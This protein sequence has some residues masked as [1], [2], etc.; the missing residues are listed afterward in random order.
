MDTRYFLSLLW[1]WGWLVILATALS[2]GLS[3]RANSKAPVLYQATTTLLVGRSLQS[4]NPNSNDLYT[5]QSLAKDYTVYATGQQVLQAT[6]NALK[7]NES[8]EALSQQ[9]DASSMQNSDTLD[10]K[11][12]N[13]DPKQAKIIADEV[14]RQLILFSPT[15]KAGDPQRQFAN[16]QMG[17]LQ[18]Q[19]QDAQAQIQDLQK[20]H[21]SATSAVTLQDLNN[22]IGVLQQKVRDWQNTY[23]QLSTFYKGSNI[24]YLSVV[25]PATVPSTPLGTS[26][27]YNVALAAVAGFLLA[28]G[29]IVVVEFVDDTVKGQVDAARTFG[30]PILGGI[31]WVRAAKKPSDRLFTITAPPSSTAEACR[32]L[33]ANVCF[34]DS[35]HATSSQL[36]LVTSPG[37]RD[38]KS[39][40]AANL[41]AAIAENGRSVILL[42]ANL[43]R[44]S[45][46]Q[47]FNLTNRE[48]LST[49]LGNENL[50]MESLVQST[51]VPS[52]RVLTS[53]PILPNPS[54]A[55]TSRVMTER[56]NQLRAL[57]EVVVVDAAAIL[58]AADVSVLATHCD[59]AVVVVR[60]EH[61]R[62]ATTRQA[63]DLLHRMGVRTP[64]VV[65]NGRNVGRPSF[66]KY[67]AVATADTAPAAQE[68]CPQLGMQNDRTSI[69][70]APSA[71][72]R[73]FA[74]GRP[75]K[76]TESHQQSYCLASGYGTCP[77]FTQAAPIARPGEAG[78]PSSSPRRLQTGH[79]GDSP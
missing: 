49:A 61:T 43:H 15:P 42:D 18:K 39:T 10:I 12:V 62:R 36:V 16:Q 56:L 59:A 54:G 66:Q 52:L 58:G 64:G 22:Q 63:I 47:Y 68:Q 37:P 20:Q 5:A 6:I 50:A 35:D 72:H 73:C 11:V 21:D 27:K 1:K 4:E 67:Y 32:F 14:A 19:I 25:S 65:L 44:P 70:L 30:L 76:V 8:W 38:G 9:I 57:A 55:L 33:G 48:G 7:L 40:V 45:A 53:G 31:R 13:T 17:Q 34:A 75:A 23:A 41:A 74:S 46:H 2:A 24:N 71:Q 69:V 3:Y 28:L 26:T 79:A 60:V 77:R 78:S 29:G 51:I